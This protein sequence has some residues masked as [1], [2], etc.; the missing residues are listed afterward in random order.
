MKYR[1]VTIA[2]NRVE[3]ELLRGYLEGEGIRVLLKPSTRPYGGE[4]YFGDAGPVEVQ[5]PEESF[6][7]AR[8]VL[9]GLEK[10]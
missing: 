8:G 10:A 9:A 2:S 3:A 7:K 1:T 6:V 4:A 5:V